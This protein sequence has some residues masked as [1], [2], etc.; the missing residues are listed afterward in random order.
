MKY[1][2]IFFKKRLVIKARLLSSSFSQAFGLMFQKP[3]PV[4]MDFGKERISLGVHMFFCFWPLDLVFLGKQK[5]ILEMKL[6]IKPFQIYTAKKAYY[7]LEL[8]AGTAKKNK[9]ATGTLLHFK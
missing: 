2:N 1:V 3:K 8:P 9:L 6:G 4:L 7:L 5:K